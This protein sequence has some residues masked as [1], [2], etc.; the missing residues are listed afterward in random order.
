MVNSDE[1]IRKISRGAK[2]SRPGNA[3]Y[4]Y[5]H[6]RKRDI[7]GNVW[8]FFSSLTDDSGETSQDLTVETNQTSN[9]TTSTVAYSL[10]ED[11]STTTFAPVIKKLSKSAVRRWWKHK[12]EKKIRRQQIKK[13]KNQ[14]P[15][16]KVQLHSQLKG[17][18]CNI[19]A[20]WL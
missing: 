18:S 8:G 4:G 14:P 2:Q 1:N 10:D 16:V 9:F 5:G 11:N 17:F 12:I 15:V 13:N 7:L 3:F 6:R 19:L 20:T